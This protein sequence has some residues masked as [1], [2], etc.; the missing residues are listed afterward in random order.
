LKMGRDNASRLSPSVHSVCSLSLSLSL[1]LSLFPLSS[2][3]APRDAHL[4][5]QRT[6]PRSHDQARK[7]RHRYRL[8]PSLHV[9][10]IK[11]CWSC[12]CTCVGEE[13][14]AGDKD[15]QPGVPPRRPVEDKQLHEFSW[16]L[17]CRRGGQPGVHCEG[18][19]RTSGYTNSRGWCNFHV[20][21]AT[22]S[23][24]TWT[25]DQ[26]MLYTYCS[27]AFNFVRRPTISRK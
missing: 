13:V 2:S 1:C 20:L 14:N 8:P 5:L 4:H 18:P 23:R 22:I 24:E 16:L 27:L 15:G 26:S 17:V 12:F 21:K 6:A 25:T 19:L 11:N 7:P 10:A 3:Q 9:C